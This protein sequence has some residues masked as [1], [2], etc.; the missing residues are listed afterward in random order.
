MK[1]DII[2][3]AK[4]IIANKLIAHIRNSHASYDTFSAMAASLDI[5][6][7]S[8]YRWRDKKALTTKSCFAKLQKVMEFT[9]AEITLIHKAIARHH[10]LSGL[11]SWKNKTSCGKEKDEGMKMPSSDI[12][13]RVQRLEKT[14][15]LTQ[16]LK[17]SS[18]KAKKLME[19]IQSIDWNV[20]GM[21]FILTR[22]NFKELETGAWSAE[23][24]SDTAKLAQELRR[25]IVILAQNPNPDIRVDHLKRMAKELDELW[26]AYSIANS[27]SPLE[28][29]ELINLER[30][31]FFT[32]E[33]EK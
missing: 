1:E 21:R 17:T 9:E 12:E 6:S 5:S 28:T 3:E 15:F 25:R 11:S 13:E 8:L 2:S 31:S 18:Q 30:Q 23:E 29:A 19:D 16:P 20:K 22:N 14:V 33:K 32:T 27:I 4:E 7:T 24:I 10:S 26:R